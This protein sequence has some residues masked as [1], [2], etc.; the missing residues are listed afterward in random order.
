M[1]Q[2]RC[3]ERA[4]YVR[5]SSGR[6]RIAAYGKRRSDRSVRTGVPGADRAMHPAPAPG[7]VAGL[8]SPLFQPSS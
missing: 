2:S 3:F 8:P 1:G 6:Y 5:Y 7:T 4:G